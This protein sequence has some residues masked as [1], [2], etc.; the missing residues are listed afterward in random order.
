MKRTRD[1]AGPARLEAFLSAPE[2]APG[3]FSLA[4]LHGFLFAVAC[5]P[6]DIPF[7]DVLPEVVRPGEGPD[8]WRRL[9]AAGVL[10]PLLTLYNEA[11]RRAAGSLPALPAMCA[12]H[13]EPMA[14]LEKESPISQ[15][16][17]GFGYGHLWMRGHWDD[18][19]SE[20]GDLEMGAS[21]SVVLFFGSRET[22]EDLHQSDPA[23]AR[24]PFESMVEEMMLDFEDALATYAELGRSL[25][26]RGR[27]RFE[28]G[29]N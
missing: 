15:W 8:R 3:T 26:S 16:I 18:H 14:N 5:A 10:Q 21:L 25:R 17:V 1:M 23:E 28:V 9:E 27:V 12:L 7:E 22:A 4:Q 29:L 11:R 20:A 6:V 2:R 13:P 24:R 19:L